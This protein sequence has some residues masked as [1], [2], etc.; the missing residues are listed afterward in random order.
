MLVRGTLGGPA[1]PARIILKRACGMSVLRRAQTPMPRAVYALLLRCTFGRWQSRRLR[2]GDGGLC[3]FV[4]LLERRVSGRK[5][6]VCGFL[7]LLPGGFEAL[8]G[9]PMLA[10]LTTSSFSP[11]FQKWKDGTARTPAREREGDLFVS[12]DARREKVPTFGPLWPTRPRASSGSTR[13]RS[14]HPRP[15]RRP[16]WCIPCTEWQNISSFHVREKTTKIEKPRASR[17]RKK[18]CALGQVTPRVL[19]R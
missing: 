8:G 5:R 9:A 13:R 2:G 7:R 3:A 6:G 15:C 16:R 18:R 14:C 10:P 12:L 17:E 1:R 19:A 11:F 4:F